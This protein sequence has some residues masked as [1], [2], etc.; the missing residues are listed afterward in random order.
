[1][2]ALPRASARKK[3]APMTEIAV[4]NTKPYDWKSGGAPS[5]IV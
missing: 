5:L 1:M 4:Y 3:I 2:A